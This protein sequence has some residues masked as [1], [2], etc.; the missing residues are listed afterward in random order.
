MI[1]SR[2]S[3]DV[4]E[5]ELAEMSIQLRRWV[6]RCA[7]VTELLKELI[8]RTEAAAIAADEKEK[9]VG[10]EARPLCSKQIPKMCS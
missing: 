10:V 3:R 4:T 9:K 2:K 5:G 6:E 7:K 8:E 1:H